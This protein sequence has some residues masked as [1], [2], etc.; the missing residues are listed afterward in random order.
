V[1][2]GNYFLNFFDLVN[3][4]VKHKKN[5]EVKKVRGRQNIGTHILKNLNIYYIL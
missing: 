1:Y 3:E 4:N 5:K 2:L